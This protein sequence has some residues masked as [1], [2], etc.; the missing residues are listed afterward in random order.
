MGV[1]EGGEVVDKVDNDLDGV[2]ESSQNLELLLN[3]LDLLLEDLL[4]VLGDGDGHSVVMA[5]YRVEKA[6]D[7]IISFFEDILSLGE[8]SVG[9]IKVEDLLDLLDLLLS[10]V[11]LIG[12]GLTVLSIANEGLLG[13]GK[14]LQSVLGLLLGVF[15]SVLDPLDI[16]LEELGLVRVLEDDL[17]LGDEVCDNVPL[18]V[19]LGEGL[20]LS[21][22]ELINILKTRGSDVSGGGEHD[23]VKELNMGLELITIGVALPV[24]VHHDSGLLDIGNQLLV[25]LDQSVKPAELC[26]LLLLGALS[27]KDLKDLLEPFSDLS[28]LQILAEGVE[29][30]SFPLE[31]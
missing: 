23:S 2:L 25:L 29:G 15:P 27:H 31:L 17:T 14:E 6:I 18:G 7:G 3:S 1:I 5:V 10:N 20:L 26:S 11:K 8:V 12:N 28:P 9:G 16:S 22:N 21:L 4:L 13:L 24:E 30:V 19:Q